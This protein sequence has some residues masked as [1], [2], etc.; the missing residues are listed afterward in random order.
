MDLASGQAASPSSFTFLICIILLSLCAR[1][2]REK[3]RLLV[4]L[5]RNRPLI[6]GD[7][8][9]TESKNS[10]S[11]DDH[12][13]DS[14]KNEEHF[15][16]LISLFYNVLTWQVMLHFQLG[17]ERPLTARNSG[18]ES[19]VLPEQSVMDVKAD[20]GLEDAWEHV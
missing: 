5:L 13:N 17:G 10:L 12:M 3:E 6:A 11:I 16:H 18:A 9:L 8:T 15:I 20:V 7:V 19:G 4:V 14:L 1:D 2:L